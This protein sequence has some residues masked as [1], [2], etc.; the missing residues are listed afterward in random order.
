[1]KSKNCSEE[2]IP[3]LD[4]FALFQNERRFMVFLNVRT[5]EQ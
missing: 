5:K 1:M 4:S 3:R 2:F